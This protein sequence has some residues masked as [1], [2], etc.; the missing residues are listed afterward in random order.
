MRVSLRYVFALALCAVAPALTGCG[1]FFVYPG[2]SGSGS[3]TTSFA[4]FANA[5]TNT[6]SGY[7]LATGTPT[8]VTG[9]PYSLGISPT[10]LVVTPGNTFLYVGSIGAL[11][12]FSINTTT[13]ALTALNSGQALAAPTIVSMDVS[14]DGNW[15]LGLDASGITVTEYAINTSTGL[16]TPATGASYSTTGTGASTPHAIRF[17]PSG[18]LVFAALGNGG[19]AVFTFNTSTG[20]LVQ[21]QSLA[22]STTASDNALIVDSTS[23]HLYVARSGDGSGINA[24]T[25]GTSGALTGISGAPFASGAGPYALTIDKTGA[26]LYAANRTDGTISGYT[27]AT[28]G[29][30]T[31]ISGSP[32]ASGVLTTSLGRDSLGKYIVAASQGG[33][34]DLSLYTF[35]STTL[36]KL[37]LSATSTTGTDPTGAVAVAMTH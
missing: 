5:T 26:Y 10:S 13:G 34:S 28:S 32:F 37:N 15:L 36:G 2:S 6:V 31:T 1:N 35:D 23:S 30:L 33:S 8:A 29:A 16:L 7:A 4:Y 22:A 18:G 21:T 17:A 27:I 19:D 11:F 24:Y 14:P 25:I 9:S 20:A 12:G 3:T